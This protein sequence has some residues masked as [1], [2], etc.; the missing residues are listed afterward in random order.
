MFEAWEDMM[1]KIISFKDI[2][3]WM[4]LFDMTYDYLTFLIDENQIKPEMV[5]HSTHDIVNHAGYKYSYDEVALEYYKCLS[6]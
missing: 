3:D 5:I 2:A 1:G 4:E 6:K